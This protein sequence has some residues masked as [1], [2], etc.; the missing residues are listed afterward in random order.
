MA[1]LKYYIFA[2]IVAMATACSDDDTV[3]KTS[4]DMKVKF[5]PVTPYEELFL[6]QSDGSLVSYSKKDG[7]DEYYLLKIKSNGIVDTTS[8]YIQGSDRGG[9]AGVVTT[10]GI[11]DDIF[12]YSKGFA[13]N[14]Y[15]EVAR[16][17]KDLKLVYRQ[18]GT[19]AQND[20][21]EL[22][23]CTPLQDGRYA[24]VLSQ[25]SE[26]WILSYYI[27]TIDG[28]GNFTPRIQIDPDKEIYNITKVTSIG[29]V[30]VIYYMNLTWQPVYAFYTIDGTCIKRLSLE[31]NTVPKQFTIGEYLY[32]YCDI[33]KA[34]INKF[35]KKGNMTSSFELPFNGTVTHLDEI[36]GKLIVSGYTTE[37]NTKSGASQEYIGAI[38]TFR[39]D[40]YSICDS[41][42]LDYNAVP[43]AVH[44]DGKGG[45]NVFLERRFSYN[46]NNYSN[47]NSIKNI[48][49]YNTDDIKK[50]QYIQSWD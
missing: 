24:M 32:I 10:N 38:Y 29:D 1:R 16:Y 3:Y 33:P 48:Y 49:I 44:S 34:I 40:D 14:N 36:D 5:V 25:M 9:Y 31:S 11:T 4:D 20:I 30:V 37:Y 17:D 2:A 42:R 7:I 39:T 50:L 26:D 22:C 43:Y 47:N 13:G 12:I 8:Y 28:D 45:Y 35:D 27:T 19:F 15:Y 6:S 21:N 46:S 18:R 23:G 41:A